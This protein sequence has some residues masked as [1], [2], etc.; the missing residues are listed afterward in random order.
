MRKP[1]LLSIALYLCTS[2]IAQPH[3]DKEQTKRIDE[4]FARYEAANPGCQFSISKNDEIIYSKVWGKADLENDVPL[5]TS[6]LIEAGSVS[7]QFTAAAILLLEQQG[8]LSLED[9]IRKYLPE[10]KDYSTVIRIKHLIHHTSGLKDWG[11]VAGLTGWPR[12]TKAYNNND[13]LEII[14]HQKT[15]NNI[16]GEEF[17]YSNSNYNLLAIIVQRTSGISLAEFTT[18]YIFIPAGMTHTQWRD[19]YKRVVPNRSVAYEKKSTGYETDMPNED[20]YGNGG[21][22]TTTEDLLKWNSFYFSGKFGNPSLVSKQIALDAFNNGVTNY[23]GAGLFIQ[24]QNGH[25]VIRHSG[26]TG[27]YRCYLAYY[28]EQKLSIAWLSNTSQYDTARY[29]VVSAVENLLAPRTPGFRPAKKEADAVV[30]L[31]AAQIKPL[32]GW[33][34]QN[35]SG[36]AMLIQ[37]KGDELQADG[38]KLVPVNDTRFTGG[39]FTFIFDK[40][41]GMITTNEDKDTIVYTVAP[42]ANLS[43]NTIKDY[44]GKYY[45]EETET[46]MTLIQ[47]ENTLQV[48]VNS[49]NIFTLR[50]MYKDG[51]AI[52]NIGGTLYFER[53]AKGNITGMKISIARARNVAFEKV[54]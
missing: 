53:D 16:P 32:E 31:T 46:A 37:V 52:S 39:N 13:A 5:T 35:K 1:F 42:P 22:L 10:I 2:I 27:S 33:Y 41:K 24:T 18:Q 9:D 14:S 7:K 3:A 49:N 38:R 19:N 26:A 12:G 21:L 43:A 50:P 4:I 20:V 6:S 40:G 8:K 34:R 45:S 51:F 15:L 54:K 44:L 47:K 28:P 17:I 11:S 23:Y 30:Q 48:W 36:A 29:N 25:K